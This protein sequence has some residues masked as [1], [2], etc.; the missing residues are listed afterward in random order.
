MRKKLSTVRSK[1]ATHMDISQRLAFPCA[2]SAQVTGLPESLE[3]EAGKRTAQQLITSL[4]RGA[5]RARKD[6]RSILRCYTMQRFN[7]DAIHFGS[8]PVVL[9]Y[10]ANLTELVGNLNQV[11]FSF[12]CS[13]LE[14]EWLSSWIYHPC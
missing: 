12:P 3:L 4:L 2:G 9:S 8:L 6:V 7:G 5:R 11:W 10:P 1:R 13:G 14:V